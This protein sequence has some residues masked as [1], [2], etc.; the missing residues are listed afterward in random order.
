MSYTWRSTLR[1][2]DFLKEGIVWRIGDGTQVNAWTGPWMPRGTTRRPVPV[3][4]QGQSIIT[5]VNE[6]IDPVSETW[7][8]EL[9]KERMMHE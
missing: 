9:V 6:L 3:A 5:K 7:D 8:E 2:R 4:H 1:G